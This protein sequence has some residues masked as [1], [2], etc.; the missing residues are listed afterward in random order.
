MNPCLHQDLENPESAI[1]MEVPKKPRKAT[2]KRNL[3]KRSELCVKFVIG[4]MLLKSE[5]TRFADEAY[6]SIYCQMF[7]EQNL[8]KYYP[9]DNVHTKHFEHFPPIE[10]ICENCGGPITLRWSV[11]KATKPFVETNAPIIKVFSKEVAN[12]ILY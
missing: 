1:N 5:R 2:K 3:R 11:D 10:S 8:T 6:C 9:S 4:Q 12:I 7:D